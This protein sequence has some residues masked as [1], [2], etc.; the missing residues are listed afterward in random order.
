MFVCIIGRN[1]V[2]AFFYLLRLV[3]AILF[4]SLALFSR[5][6]LSLSSRDTQ[7]GIFSSMTYFSSAT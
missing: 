7:I 6:T 5:E 3:W 4:I 1:S 2:R